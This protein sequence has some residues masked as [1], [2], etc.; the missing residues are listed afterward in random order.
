[1]HPLLLHAIVLLLQL[2]AVSDQEITFFF[3]FL[4]ALLFGGNLYLTSFAFLLY[5][6]ERN[7]YEKFEIKS[8]KLFR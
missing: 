7:I 3:S 1:M 4:V 5:L 8:S 6:V 2:I